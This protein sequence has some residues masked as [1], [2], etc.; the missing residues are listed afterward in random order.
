MNKLEVFTE[1]IS[2]PKVV[3]YDS[4]KKLPIFFQSGNVGTWDNGNWSNRDTWSNSWHNT[5]NNE[6]H[7]SW[8]NG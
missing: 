5:W 2:T 8:H 3:S 6:W 7:N 1:K 4:F